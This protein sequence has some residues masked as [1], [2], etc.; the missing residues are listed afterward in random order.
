[1]EISLDSSI[2]TEKFLSPI[3]SKIKVVTQCEVLLNVMRY[4][5]HHG[6]PLRYYFCK[7]NQALIV[8]FGDNDHAIRGLMRFIEMTSKRFIKEDVIHNGGAPIT[9][10][11][12]IKLERRFTSFIF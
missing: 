12:G 11:D 9:K 4:Y 6:K 3:S 8:D 10:D 2:N 1:M 5:L 7:C